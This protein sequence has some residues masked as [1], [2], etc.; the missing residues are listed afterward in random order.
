MTIH[1]PAHG[2]ILVLID[3]F[4]LLNRPMTGLAANTLCDMRLMIEG[5][6]VRKHV[7]LHPGNRKPSIKLLTEIFPPVAVLILEFSV[8]MAIHANIQ[9]RNARM[10]PLVHVRM[11]ITAVQREFSRVNLMTKWNGLLRRIVVVVTHWRDSEGDR[12]HQKHEA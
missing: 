7:H 5:Y 4:H 11:T 12:S 3:A 2:K 6:K 1:T 9:T 10:A 8:A